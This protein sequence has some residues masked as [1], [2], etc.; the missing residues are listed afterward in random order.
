VRLDHS[1]LLWYA[2]KPPAPAQRTVLAQ[3][4]YEPEDLVS[5]FF[6]DS[7][8]PGALRL[9]S[10][11]ADMDVPVYRHNATGTLVPFWLVGHMSHDLTAKTR[12]EMGDSIERP[13]P[14]AA[15]EFLVS[16]C[17]YVGF[18]DR[19]AHLEILRDIVRAVPRDD[20]LVVIAANEG[21]PGR[22]PNERHV[23]LN[24]RIEMLAREF[25]HLTV[26]RPGDFITGPGDVHDLNHFDRMV[27]F[28]MYGAIRDS[29][30][31]MAEA[32]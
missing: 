31:P 29:A 19:A 21:V 1:L 23:E 13:R 2:L 22:P 15:W 9:I 6:D 32:Q 27:Y 10:F 12:E 30:S 3:L 16:E 14:Q 8:L 17:E 7:G 11:W 25:G 20:F 24:E 4:G 5:R 28:R 18:L 26:I